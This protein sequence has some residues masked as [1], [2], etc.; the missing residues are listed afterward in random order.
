MPR[1]GASHDIDGRYLPDSLEQA[2]EKFWLMVD[3]TDGCWNWTGYVL[4]SGYGNWVNRKFGTSR[5]HRIAYELIVGPI[6]EELQIDHLCRNRLC[7]NPGHME[8]VTQVINVRRS[9]V[10]KLTEQDVEG[11]RS[12]CA[13]ADMSQKEIALAFGIS[14][15]Q[16]SRINTRKRWS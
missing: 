9:T 12:L 15:S 14:Q 16:V 13:T 11:I 10:A 1:S 5:P 4:P 8:A 3:K 6:S 2:T 7:C